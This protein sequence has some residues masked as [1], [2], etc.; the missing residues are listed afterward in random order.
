MDSARAEIGAQICRA[1]VLRLF[2]TAPML[3]AL[4]GPTRDVSMKLLSIAMIKQAVLA[5][6]AGFGAWRMG[7]L[8]ARRR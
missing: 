3:W 1:F 7:R 2:V 8:G 5:A 4:I 6:V